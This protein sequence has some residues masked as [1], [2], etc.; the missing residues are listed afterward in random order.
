MRII[1]FG[2][3]LILICF[4]KSKWS[5]PVQVLHLV[6]QE[7][8]GVPSVYT[9][10]SSGISH[11]LLTVWGLK[12]YW[13]CA[14]SSEGKL[15]HGTVFEDPGYAIRGIIRGANDG[16]HIFLAMWSQF[17]E[18][19][20]VNFTESTD[21]GV[22]WSAPIHLQDKGPD[23]WLQEMLYVEE[24]G[25]ILIFY[26]LPSTNITLMV[27]KAP[28][29]KIFSSE[30]PVVYTSHDGFIARGTYFKQTL[31]FFFVDPFNKL[32][33]VQSN[34][35]GV[36][37]SKP[38]EIDNG[39]VNRILDVDSNHELTDKIFVATLTNEEPARLLWSTDNGK[40]FSKP[41]VITHE[42]VSST[43]EGLEICSSKK[44]G[45]L[46]SF[47]TTGKGHPEFSHFDLK[48]M[49]QEEKEQPFTTP[50]IINSNMDCYSTGD[51]KVNAF[52][53]QERNNDTYLL[54][55]QE[56]E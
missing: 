2:I 9:D 38:R 11:V 51:L 43:D 47:F 27:S 42:A 13:Y 21:G 20:K 32:G 40:T 25:R 10:Q 5:E 56:T 6:N 15:L 49:K 37:W 33:Y 28:G 4:V 35:N 8:V 36:T 17:D 12:Q 7:T 19:D 1:S 45:I 16:K 18:S 26:L 29:S 50:L 46:A 53:T 48:T 54:F 44:G 30:I 55:S 34:N 23:R 41:I 14:V 31:H 22:S 39:I 3:T 24:T 52:V